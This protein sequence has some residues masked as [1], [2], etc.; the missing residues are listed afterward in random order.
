[1][2]D[3]LQQIIALLLVAIAVAFELIRRARKKKSGKIGCDDC[4]SG[5]SGS[6]EQGESPVKFYKQN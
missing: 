2:D 5:D 4:D 6:N 1:M 3:S